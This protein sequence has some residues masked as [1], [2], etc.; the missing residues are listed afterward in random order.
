MTKVGVLRDEYN[1]TIEGNPPR[2]VKTLF[3]YEANPA[4]FDWVHRADAWAET[5]EQ[6]L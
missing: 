5:V 2:F 1:A 6:K 3:G 4:Y